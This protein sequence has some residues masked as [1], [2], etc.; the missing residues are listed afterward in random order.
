MVHYVLNSA[1]P[2]PGSSSAVFVEFSPNGRFLAV[3]DHVFSSLYV[4]DRLAG[5]HPTI[6]ATTPAEPTA[7]VWENSKE[8]YVG[9]SDGRFIHYRV[10]LRYN[11]LVEGFA[12]NAFYGGLPV[13][14]IALD[15][16]SRTLVLS[17]G[18]DVFA[19]RR[20]CATSAFYLPIIEVV[21]LSC[22]S[23]VLFRRKYLEPL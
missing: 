3:G 12:N 10:D 14:A 20:V 13:T 9:L 5:F 19:F 15:G 6:S 18:L 7:L 11:K 4:L 17:E 23:R 1:I 16:E 21:T 22:S 8:F 2:S